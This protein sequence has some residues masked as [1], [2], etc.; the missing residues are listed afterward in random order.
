MH[1]CPLDTKE[2]THHFSQWQP[3]NILVS[4]ATF[5]FSDTFP[6]QIF[7]IQIKLCFYHNLVL[8][9]ARNKGNDSCVTSQHLLYLKKTSYSS[10]VIGDFSLETVSFSVASSICGT[11]L[12][13]LG[14]VMRLL[15]VCGICGSSKWRAQEIRGW[16]KY[17]HTLC[18]A[19]TILWGSGSSAKYSFS[20]SEKNQPLL[21]ILDWTE[22]WF[23]MFPAKILEG[24][25]FQLIF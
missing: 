19:I 8:L 5:I 16:W 24:N 11:C 18:Q 1:V 22:V 2:K 3:G 14:R 6:H 21:G 20:S 13:F 4:P 25:Q 17:F 7:T 10:L 12:L 23:N 15:E 9:S